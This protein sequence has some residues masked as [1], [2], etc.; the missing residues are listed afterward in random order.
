MYKALTHLMSKL[1]GPCQSSFVPNRQNGDN[2]VV[3]QEIFHSIR[4]KSIVNT[5]YKSNWLLVG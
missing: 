4:T 2:I 5:I 3:A 1:V